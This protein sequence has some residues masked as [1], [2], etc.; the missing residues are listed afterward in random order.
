MKL[1]VIIANHNHAD[2]IGSAISSALAIA[3]PMKSA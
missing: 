1:S 2:F 3:E